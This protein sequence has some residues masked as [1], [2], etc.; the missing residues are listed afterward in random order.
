MLDWLVSR[1]AGS[2]HHEEVSEPAKSML[3]MSMAGSDLEVTKSLL[4][5]HF[6]LPNIFPDRKL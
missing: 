1:V 3:A 5:E 6:A 2:D 4:F